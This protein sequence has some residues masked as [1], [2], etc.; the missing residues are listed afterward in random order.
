MGEELDKMIS[1]YLTILGH[2]SS[3]YEFSDDNITPQQVR[4]LEYIDK[5]PDCSMSHICDFF[6]LSPSRATRVINKLVKINLIQRQNSEEDRRKVILSIT[7]QARQKIIKRR[8]LR[9][10]VLRKLF[11]NLTNNDIILQTKIVKKLVI[12]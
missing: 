10:D 11:R 7:N 5:D 9:L 2:V 6:K 8:E 3:K 4:I 1:L 12:E